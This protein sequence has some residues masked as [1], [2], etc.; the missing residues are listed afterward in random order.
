MVE[1][2]SLNGPYLK[3]VNPKQLRCSDCDESQNDQRTSHY[4]YAV[5]GSSV[6]LIPSVAGGKS[7]SSFSLP[8]PQKGHAQKE[9]PANLKKAHFTPHFHFLFC[10]VLHYRTTFC[11]CK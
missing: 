11:Q 8:P 9:L 6:A 1:S 3:A 5:K 7:P 2:R 10:T 4:Q